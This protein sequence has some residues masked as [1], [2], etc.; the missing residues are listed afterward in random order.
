VQAELVRTVRA[1]AKQAPA[2]QA[3]GP[4]F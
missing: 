2:E 3:S 1:P 4:E